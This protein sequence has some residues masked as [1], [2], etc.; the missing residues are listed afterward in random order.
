MYETVKSLLTKEFDIS[1]DQ[2]APESTLEDLGLDSLASVEFALA[3]EK[4]LGV[5]IT[6][7]EVVE[8]ERL[9][10]ILELVERRKRA[11]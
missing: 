3:L 6:D 7:D 4:G 9:D 5:E 10:K 2:I 1:E 11:S 8:L